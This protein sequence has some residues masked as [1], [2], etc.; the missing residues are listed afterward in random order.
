VGFPGVVDVITFAEVEAAGIGT[1]GSKVPHQRP[2]GTPHLTTPYSALARDRAAYLG[3]AV[4]A[5]VAESPLAALEAAAAVEVEYEPLPAVVDGE[6]AL[7]NDAQPVWPEHP[8]NLCFVQELGDRAACDAAFAKAHQV[9]RERLVISRVATSSLEGR[10]AIGEYDRGSGRYTLHA[11][12]QMPHETGR[13]IAALLGLSPAD[14]RV[15]SPDIGGG[16][17]LKLPVYQEYLLVLLAAK[18]C[19][20]PVKWIADRSEILPQ[21]SACARQCLRRCASSRRRGPVSRAEGRDDRQSRRLCRPM[22]PACADR[23]SRRAGRG[24]QDR[25][26]RRPSAGASSP[27]RRRP[28]PSGAPGAPRRPI[29]PS[30]SS[31]RQ[32][33]SSALDPAELRRINMIEPA[34]MPYDTGLMFTL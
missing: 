11:G 25:R 23:Q 18:R 4:A 33:P 9:T 17:G 15:V 12:L 34:Q 13:D 31:T 27:T 16:F 8:D 24:L 26:F 20:R 30:G 7:A 21:R 14:I 22:E 1:V 32:R 3:D 28:A 5:V 2:D 10:G 6:A 29:A 19:G